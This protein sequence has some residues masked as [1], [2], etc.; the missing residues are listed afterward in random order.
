MIIVTEEQIKK[1]KKYL[2]NIESVIE[3]D[4]YD[5]FESQV[6]H[7]AVE[8]GLDENDEMTPLGLELQ[9]LYDEIYYQND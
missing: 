6:E 5:E 3:A 8:Y 1:L 2:P 4:D 7:L 9:N